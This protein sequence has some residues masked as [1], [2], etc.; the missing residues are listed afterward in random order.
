MWTKCLPRDT[1]Q[2]MEY[3]LRNSN[4]IICKH[5]NLRLRVPGK[6]FGE[7]GQSVCNIP[8]EKQIGSVKTEV[9]FR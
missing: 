8:T 6:V 4:E 1:I 5:R 9:Q 7:S 3:T 2:P